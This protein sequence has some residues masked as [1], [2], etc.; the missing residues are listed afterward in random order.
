MESA[1]KPVAW[2][3]TVSEADAAGALKRA[4]SRAGA[5]KTGQVDHIMKIHSLNPDSL[6]DH[7][8][9]YKTLMFAE[10]P[11]S[12]VQRELIGVVVSA[13]NSLRILTAASCAEPPSVDRRPGINSAGRSRLYRRAAI[14]SGS[15][16]ARLRYEIDAYT[17][18]DV[19]SGC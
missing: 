10:S 8:H 5:A 2:I 9:L 16:D 19:S 4:Y 14:V 3:E 6:V 17:V 18:G 13:I 7:L 12:R 15:S 1:K 11:L